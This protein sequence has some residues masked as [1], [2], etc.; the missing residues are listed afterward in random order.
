VRGWWRTRTMRCSK[1]CC[2]TVPKRMFGVCVCVY[3]RACVCVCMYACVHVLVSNG[4]SLSLSLSLSLC[5]C[6]SSGIGNLM[7]SVSRRLIPFELDVKYIYKAPIKFKSKD[8]DSKGDS[9]AITRKQIPNS[10]LK[11]VS[12]EYCSVLEKSMWLI[13]FLLLLLLLLLL[14]YS[15][16]RIVYVC[17]CVVYLTYIDG[18]HSCACRMCRTGTSLNRVGV[19]TIKQMAMLEVTICPVPSEPNA[20]VCV[21]ACVP[22]LTERIYICVCVLHQSYQRARL[23]RQYHQRESA[24]DKLVAKAFRALDY[25]RK[26]KEPKKKNVPAKASLESKM[27]KLTV[28]TRKLQGT[29]KLSFLF[30]IVFCCNSCP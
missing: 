22:W 21:C 11:T 10:S 25:F 9:D 30:A 18:F 23:K 16:I 7:S 14:L 2:W 17:V 8:K 15:T 1:I 5:L 19:R 4:S 24:L 26:L 27:N 3:V 29:C 12:S 28:K 13:L 6:C 20:F